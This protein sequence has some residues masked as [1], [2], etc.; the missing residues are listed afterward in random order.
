MAGALLWGLGMMLAVL[1]ALYL[2]NRLETGRLGGILL[3]YFIG[4][5][6]AWLPARG[7]VLLLARRARAETRF[8]AHFFCL[9]VFTVGFTTLAFALDTA[10]SMRSGMR[11]P[12][13]ASGGCSSSSRSGAPPTSSSSSACRFSCRSACRFCWQPA[14]AGARDAGRPLFRRQ[15]GSRPWLKRLRRCEARSSLIEAAAHP[16]SSLIE[17]S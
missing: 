1:V 12:S 4:G 16:Q 17:E 15:S 2:R 6:L 13:P 8:A 14:S 10:P 5:A 9:T 3:I 7:M 11:P